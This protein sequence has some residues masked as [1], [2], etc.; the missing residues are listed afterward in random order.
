LLKSLFI[1]LPKIFDFW[2]ER[3]QRALQ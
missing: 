2:E 3:R 1:G